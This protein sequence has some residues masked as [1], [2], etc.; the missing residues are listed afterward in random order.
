MSAPKRLRN[1]HALSLYLLHQYPKPHA[2]IPYLLLCFGRLALRKITEKNHLLR[3]HRNLR[4]SIDRSSSGHTLV[5]LLYLRDFVLKKYHVEFFDLCA[6][7]MLYYFDEPA[8]NK[9]DK[10]FCLWF[11]HQMANCRKTKITYSHCLIHFSFACLQKLNY[12]VKYLG[13]V[14][15]IWAN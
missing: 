1:S 12:F 6:I 8:I 3:S 2:P 5:K 13:E 14:T 11:N 4:N 9:A 10:S 7:K 15:E